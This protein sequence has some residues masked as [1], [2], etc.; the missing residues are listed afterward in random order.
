MNVARILYPIKV[1]GPGNRIGIWVCG[2][3]RKCPGC[4]NPELWESQPKYEITI[5][6][7]KKLIESIV[8]EH[9]IDGFTITGGEPFD[10]TPDLLALISYLSTINRDIL[11]YTGYK[12]E[13]LR[14]IPNKDT[15]NI[16]SSIAVLIDGAYIEDLNNDTSLRGSDNQRIF[17]LNP[18]YKVYYEN[19]LKTANNQIQN[20]TTIDGIISVGIHKKDFAKK[21]IEQICKHEGGNTNG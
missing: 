10:Q 14:K 2:C 8:S 13:D 7:L 11:I 9:K 20:F 4:S 1:L 6:N 19:F 21:I 17:I 5:P 3:S 12:I 15:E 16:L 18:K